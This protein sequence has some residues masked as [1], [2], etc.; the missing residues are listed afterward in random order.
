MKKFFGLVLIVLGGLSLATTG[1][2]AIN[3]VIGAVVMLVGLLITWSAE[4][5]QGKDTD[6]SVFRSG[7]KE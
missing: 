6:V 4:T 3:P 5:P 2:G 1:D 7:R